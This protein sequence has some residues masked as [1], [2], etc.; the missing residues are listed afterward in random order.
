MIKMA[1][2]SSLMI[3]YHYICSFARYLTKR[4]YTVIA[5]ERLGGK[6]PG[7]FRK[8]EKLPDETDTLA[9]RL[10]GTFVNDNI[11]SCDLS[12]Y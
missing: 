7:K 12:H 5:P 2:P 11:T 8:E 4:S 10:A 9:H 1:T 6:L 3:K